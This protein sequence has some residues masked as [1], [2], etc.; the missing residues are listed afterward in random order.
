[1]LPPGCDHVLC[2]A[3]PQRLDP[4]TVKKLPA[5]EELGVPVS[6]NGSVSGPKSQNG[7][8]P[9]KPPVGSPSPRLS[10]TPPHTPT[11][12]DEPGKK[13]KKSSPLQH[14]SPSR[15]ASQGF[16]GTSNG[17]GSRSE[18]HR[19]GS[20]DGRGTALSTSPRLPA[21]VTANGH[22]P[23]AGGASPELDGR[24]SCSSSPEHSASSDPANAPQTPKSGAA[25]LGDSQGTHSSAAGHS[26][27]LPNGDDAKAVKPKAPVLSN[28]TTEPASIMSPPPAKKLA[29][30]AK[31]VGVWES[32]RR[33]YICRAQG[34]GLALV[35]GC[36][37][38]CWGLW[39]PPVRGAK[40]SQAFADDTGLSWGEGGCLGGPDGV[41]LWLLG[42]GARWQVP[43]FVR[44]QKR[45][46]KEASRGRWGRCWG[47]AGHGLAGTSVCSTKLDDVIVVLRFL[48]KFPSFFPFCF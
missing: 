39:A 11:I 33:K 40:P 12:L 38:L 36:E 37:H 4:V 24:D 2:S 18:G 30:S 7:Y 3:L 48:F 8:V 47:R 5:T 42:V 43:I 45:L 19:Q 1:M 25:H 41:T 22:G 20:W 27:A 35:W 14:L 44:R 17:S 10:K 15:K 21:R 29:L 34:A 9:P 32:S 46:P 31:K 16:H 6:R 23:K 28:A 26:R 13:V